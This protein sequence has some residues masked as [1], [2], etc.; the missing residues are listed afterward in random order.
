M[1]VL[2]T[3]ANGFVGGSVAAHLLSRG[4]D[5]IRLSRRPASAGAA[6]GQAMCDISMPGAAINIAE[7]VQP[8]EAIVHAAA[9]LEKDLF[10]PS[11][12][13]TNC[14]GTQEMLRLAA[15]WKSYFVFTSSVPVIGI[16]QQL[17]IT[18]EHP[19]CPRSAYH[20]SKLYGEHLVRLAGNEGIVG[21][22]LRLTAPIGPGMPSNRILAVFIRQAISN[23][24]ISLAGRG[25]RQQDYVDVRDIAVAVERCLL[26][27]PN[28]TFN[29][30]SGHSISNQALANKCVAVL[31]SQSTIEFNGK[32]DPEEG[33]R[34]EVCIDRARS[35]FGYEP[36]VSLEESVNDLAVG[37]ACCNNQ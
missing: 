8:C 23:K 10:A 27:R 33:W 7:Q 20:A 29:I 6:A 30:G 4:M 1:R 14:V 37:Y 24:P 36:G 16:P 12:P 34:W 19:I 11:V 3:G 9:S 35:G 31:R 2:V 32:P 26:A 15:L 13:L 25:T 17:P 28:G 22:T 21:A 5:V 18:E